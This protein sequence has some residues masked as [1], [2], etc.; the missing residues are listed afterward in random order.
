MSRHCFDV[1]TDCSRLSAKSLWTDPKLVDLLEHFFL[2]VCIIWIFVLGIYR[3]HQGFLSKKGSFIKSSSDSNANNH[4][5]T[6]VRS[7]CFDCF[8]DKILDSLDAGRRLKHTDSTHVFASEAFGANCDLDVFA[9]YDFC[10]KHRRSIVS[11]ISSADRILHYGFTE[12]AVG[13][14][15]ADA[16][17]NCFGEVSA[18]NMYVLSDF[19]EYTCH[20][21]ILAD[22]HLF[23]LCN[24]VVFDD[25]IQ[26]ST[27]NLAILTCTTG[28]DRF[29][30]V[31]RKHLIGF[32]TKP[33]DGVRDH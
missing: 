3:A 27:G 6:W 31:V 19:E 33:L 4:R 13:V 30:D 8:K 15:S 11:S 23:I 21:G 12:I 10:I 17:I 29:L 7:G 20:S 2:E 25:I 22:W 5:W 1:Q 24:L 26:N 9:W 28:L 32:D 16:F 18:C 14:S